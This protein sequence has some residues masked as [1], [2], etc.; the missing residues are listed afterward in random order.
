MKC[1]RSGP[2]KLGM[3][4]EAWHPLAR[5]RIEDLGLESYDQR[6]LADGF[7]ARGDCGRI[8]RRPLARVMGP[9]AVTP[10]TFGEGEV[11]TCFASGTR[12]LRLAG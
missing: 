11:E 8:A 6:E 2:W 9:P 10:V 4:R 5:D 12:A 3:H 7:R 1:P